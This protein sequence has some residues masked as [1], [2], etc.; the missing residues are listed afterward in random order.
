MTDKEVAMTLS[1]LRGAIYSVEANGQSV[2]SIRMGVTL[3]DTIVAYTTSLL[4]NNQ[5]IGELRTMFG[6][7]VKIDYENPWTLK[8]LTAVDVP[9]IRESEVSGNGND[10]TEHD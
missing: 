6:L 7:P 5:N 4:V 9:V 8:V 1:M 10:R 3:C 2:D